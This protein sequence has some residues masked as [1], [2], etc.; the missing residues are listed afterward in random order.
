MQVWYSMVVLAVRNIYAFK[1]KEIHFTNLYWS[2]ELKTHNDDYD[3]TEDYEGT[4]I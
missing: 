4:L 2:A 3:Q 1:A